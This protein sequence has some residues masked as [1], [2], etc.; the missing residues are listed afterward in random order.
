MR[1]I[2]FSTTAFMST[3]AD[4]P[5][6]S[7]RAVSTAAGITALATA[8]DTTSISSG[9]DIGAA[10]GGATGASQ[11]DASLVAFCASSSH[12]VGAVENHEAALDRGVSET[13]VCASADGS[14]AAS[15][16]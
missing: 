10:G 11:V 5:F 3:S 1:A 2:T 6:A 15:G 13:K 14:G 12:G 9:A 7:S 4:P 16:A 8:P